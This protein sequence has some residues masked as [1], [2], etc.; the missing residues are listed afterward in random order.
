MYNLRPL[1]GKSAVL[2]GFGR[3]RPWRRGQLPAVIFSSASQARFWASGLQDP[4]EEDSK[5]KSDSNWKSTAF[6]MLETAG[7]TM[8]SI[9]ILGYVKLF[10]NASLW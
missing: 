3:V 5:D 7:A 4:V 1:V 9:A 2:T 10:C 8:A 6:K